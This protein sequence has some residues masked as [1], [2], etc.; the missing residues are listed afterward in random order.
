VVG[1]LIVKVLSSSSLEE[2]HTH[3]RK[4]GFLIVQQLAVE[5]PL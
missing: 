3:R 1:D 2:V 5:D 4:N